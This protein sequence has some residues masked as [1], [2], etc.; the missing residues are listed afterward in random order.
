MKTRHF[1]SRTRNR[2]RL[3]PSASPVVWRYRRTCRDVQWRLSWRTTLSLAGAKEATGR[4]TDRSERVVGRGR[5]RAGTPYPRVPPGEREGEADDDDKCRRRGGARLVTS[6]RPRAYLR[7]SITSCRRRPARRIKQRGAV[8]ARLRL[9][10]RVL[11]GVEASVGLGC[12]RRVP[13]SRAFWGDVSLSL[14]GF[15]QSDVRYLSAAQLLQ[16]GHWWYRPFTFSPAICS[17]KDHAAAS[18]AGQRS[19]M[20]RRCCESQTEKR[21]EI[22]DIGE[23]EKIPT[24]LGKG[25]E[26]KTRSRLWRQNQRASRLESRDI[27]HGNFRLRP[28]WPPVAAGSHPHLTHA[29]CHFKI[30][31]A[32]QFEY[33]AAPELGGG[34]RRRIPEETRRPAASS[35]TIP[36]CENPVTRPGIKLGSAWWK[37]RVLIAQPPRP[38]QRRNARVG[39]KREIPE[40]TH[41]A[42]AKIRETPSVIEPHFSEVGAE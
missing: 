17:A 32:L 26:M 16:V 42:G 24:R 38:L 33:G 30:M 35:G 34:G 31:L 3:I 19:R 36:T 9:N 40:K 7:V 14:P 8:S 20:N 10:T 13:S 27:L 41:R 4:I 18:P 39:A 12:G 25:S 1:D 5:G 29:W 6:G 21:I 28:K 11:W 22:G 37:A 2:T 23:P 15:I